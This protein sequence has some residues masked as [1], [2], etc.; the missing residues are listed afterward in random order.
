MAVDRTLYQPNQLSPLM[1]MLSHPPPVQ[2][3][4]PSKGLGFAGG[5]IRRLNI[6]MGNIGFCMPCLVGWF[7]LDAQGTL[8]LSETPAKLQTLS[9]VL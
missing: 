4:G 3:L 6:N 1:A 9:H 7:G 5:I 2:I 8:F